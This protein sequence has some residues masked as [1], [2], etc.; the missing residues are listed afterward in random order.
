MPNPASAGLPHPAS[1]DTTT[2]GVV[3]DQ[4]TGLIWQA[5][6]SATAAYTWLGAKNYCA[7]LVLAGFS[8]WR[9]PSRIELTSLVDFTIASPGPVLDA[10][11]F[12][13]AP[14]TTFWTASIEVP[15]GT[16]RAWYIQF[17][18]GFPFTDDTNV[19][20]SARCVR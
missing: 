14:N 15:Y 4:V 8:D 19:K 2:P 5:A 3:R 12:P 13:G 6:V 7:K 11:A 20:Y 9:L 1:Y 18:D 16:D 10:S 17:D